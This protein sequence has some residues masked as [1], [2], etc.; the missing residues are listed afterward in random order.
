MI[1]NP[2]CLAY[3]ENP[4]I[5]QIMVQTKKI[6]TMKGL[7]DYNDYKSSLPCISGKSFNQANQGLD[8][9]EKSQP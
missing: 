6:T 1:I 8:K 2:H 5:R 4:L 7:I 9:K 3:Q